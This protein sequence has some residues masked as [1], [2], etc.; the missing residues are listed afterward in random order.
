MFQY[1]GP[2]TLVALDP[3]SVLNLGMK[4]SFTCLVRIWITWPTVGNAINHGGSLPLNN[5]K[6]KM[7]IS[8]IY[9]CSIFIHFSSFMIGVTWSNFLALPSA[10]LAP[11]FWSFWTFWSWVLL[12]MPHNLQQYF[13]WLK[14]K[15]LLPLFE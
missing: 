7:H 3:I 9:C 11:K 6:T 13:I 14:T 15:F 8:K 12:A 10:T 1:I 4:R 5:L 2:C